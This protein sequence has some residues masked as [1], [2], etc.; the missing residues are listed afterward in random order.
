MEMFLFGLVA[1]VIIGGWVIDINLRAPAPVR[2]WLA[3]FFPQ[4][5][6]EA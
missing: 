4:D 6:K 2:R 5:D 3:S 1:G